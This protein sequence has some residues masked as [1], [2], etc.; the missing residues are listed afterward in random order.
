MEKSVCLVYVHVCTYAHVCLSVS[1]CA[2][3]CVLGQSC[4][5]VYGYVPVCIGLC[6]VQ[7]KTLSHLELV[8][9]GSREPLNMVGAGLRSSTERF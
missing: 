5:C 4:I 6:G 2:C 1:D 7:K 9:A 3:M 8:L